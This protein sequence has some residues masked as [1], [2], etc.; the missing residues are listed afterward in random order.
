MKKLYHFAI[1]FSGWTLLA[2]K[3]P[4]ASRPS[5]GLPSPSLRSGQASPFEKGGLRGIFPKGRRPG[6]ERAAGRGE[7]GVP[8]SA[9]PLWRG[10]VGVLLDGG[11]DEVLRSLLPLQVD[12]LAGR[13]KVLRYALPGQPPHEG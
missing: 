3:S 7:A 4:C 10:H 11:D 8:G 6:G 5:T 2:Q 13:W 1:L 12:G 9:P